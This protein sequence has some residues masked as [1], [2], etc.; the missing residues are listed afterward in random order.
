MGA[1]KKSEPND[2]FFHGGFFQEHLNIIEPIY[3]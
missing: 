3:T 2:S 1:D